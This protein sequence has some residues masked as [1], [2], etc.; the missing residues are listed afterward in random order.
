MALQRMAE[1]DSIFVVLIYEETV[2]TLIAGMGI[3]WLV[4]ALL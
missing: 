1:E 3:F 2:Q 4:R